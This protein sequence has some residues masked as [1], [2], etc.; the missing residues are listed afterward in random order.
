MSDQS[1]RVLVIYGG[2]SG[3]RRH[4]DQRARAAGWKTRLASRQAELV[5]A[6]DGTATVLW[7]LDEETVSAVSDHVGRIA[8]IQKR[9]PGETIEAFVS[10]ALEE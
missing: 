4:A 10:R 1:L 9:T 6:L 8:V 7:L 2:D 5:K 3:M